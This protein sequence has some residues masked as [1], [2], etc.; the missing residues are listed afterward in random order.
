MLAKKQHHMGRARMISLSTSANI[1]G[2]EDCDGAAMVGSKRAVDEPSAKKPKR[3]RYIWSQELH[4]CFCK[5]VNLLGIELARPQ[6]IRKAMIG[7]SAHCHTLSAPCRRRTFA[8]TDAMPRVRHRALRQT[9]RL[10]RQSNWA[11]RGPA[12][13]HTR[14][15]SRT[16]RNIGSTSPRS[17]KK[18][19][20]TP[21]RLGRCRSMFSGRWR[22]KT[23]KR[24]WRPTWLSTARPI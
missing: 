22:T 8:L 24:R 14:P 3:Q 4:A 1:N 23:S 7:A 19:T 15:S 5:A 18:W 21:L 6:A 2:A 16:C 10:L 13:P 12:Y 11:S 17:Q 9:V 20:M